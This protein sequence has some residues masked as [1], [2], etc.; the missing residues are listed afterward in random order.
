MIDVQS[1]S[2]PLAGDLPCGPNLEY[3]LDF[4]ALEA[5]ARDKPDQEFGKGNV[6]A[7]EEA[8][9]RGVLERALDLSARTRDL[10]IAVLLTRAL[11]RNEGLAGT[12]E[13]LSV[14]AGMLESSWDL[15]HPQLDPDDGNDPIMRMN[16]L[17]VLVDNG[18]LLRDLRRIRFMSTRG[19]G[20][21]TVRQVEVGIGA[22]E[23]VASDDV[24]LARP[25]LEAM[26][27]DAA[28]EGLSNGARA[29]M[30]ALARINAVLKEHV[31][32][33]NRVDLGP[34]SARLKPLAAFFSSI[35]PDPVAET[36]APQEAEVP[37]SS[38]E[39][40]GSAAAVP[41]QAALTGDIRN[42]EDVI[43]VLGKICEYLERNEPTNPA[44]LLIRR[45]LRLMSMNFVDILKD[46]APE[47]VA[48]INK[49]AGLSEG[50]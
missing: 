4:Q 49:I 18:A 26:L 50:G 13:G 11:T 39:G 17:A 41:A 23:K 15:V 46:V 40:T 16:T 36:V 9:W 1:L 45:A 22:A 30:E 43:R 3:D 24:V 33:Q 2:G 27:R 29:C 47:G 35:V 28:Q 32:I 8:D 5:A 21:V 48:A 44:P 25:A 38:Q 7:G 37:T 34:L 19:G 14:I 20:T 12:A 42:R 10:R 31:E 6:I